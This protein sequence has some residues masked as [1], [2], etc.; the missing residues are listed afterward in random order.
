MTGLV[1]CGSSPRHFGK[2]PEGNLR[3]YPE[4]ATQGP[5]RKTPTPGPRAGEHVDSPTLYAVV[6]ATD[7]HV[8]DCERL[9]GVEE[10]NRLS[11][12]SGHGALDAGYFPCATCKPG[13]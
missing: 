9:E 3:P 1:G 6:G 7:Y 4:D 2:A 8:H 12:L 11:F 13:P 10:K 5:A